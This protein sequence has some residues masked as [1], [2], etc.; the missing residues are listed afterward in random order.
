MSHNAHL[1]VTTNIGCFLNCV[2]C[3]QEKL[4]KS[5]GNDKIKNL[6]LDDFKKYID[7]IPVEVDIHFSGFCEPFINLYCTEMIEYAVRN[8]H[9]VSIF[10]TLMGTTK[11]DYEKLSNYHFDKICIHIPDNEGRSKF[12]ITDDYINLLEYVLKNKL[13]CNKFWINCHG[14]PHKKIE[15]LINEPIDTFIID[16]AGNVE[17]EGTTKND[18]YGMFT[19][20]AVGHKLN[21]N[22]LL[23]NGDIVLCCMDYELKH[24]LGNLNYCSYNELFFGKEAEKIR[25]TFDGKICEDILCEKCN[26]AIKI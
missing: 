17:I 21:Q 15:H 4:I 18:I 24:V 5:Y 25:K 3:P 1:E 9:K 12:K 16:R 8:R 11:Q 14:T 6:F 10:T 7:K 19:C 23:P 26:R 13:S 22:V 20:S 2:F